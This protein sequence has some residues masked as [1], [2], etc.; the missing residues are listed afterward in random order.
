MPRPDLS[1]LNSDEKDAL[2]GALLER[3]EELA[4]R[5][6]L[7]S[8]NSGQPPAREGCQKPARGNKQREKTGRN[9]GGPAGREGT[10]LRQG[11][12]PDKGS[13]YFPPACTG[14]G[15]ALSREH[16]TGHQE[17]QVCD[18]GQPVVEGTEHRAHR[19]GCP[20]CGTQTLAAFPA[21]VSAAAQYGATSAAGRDIREGRWGWPK[22]GGRQDRGGLWGSNANGG[23]PSGEACH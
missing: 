21:A 11:A 10:P 2:M 5:L 17:R 9:S 3:S 19:C 12:T 22:L 1:R 6:G 23:E 15:G 14:C 13:E 4:R 18:I 7:N 8:A 20:A 16:A